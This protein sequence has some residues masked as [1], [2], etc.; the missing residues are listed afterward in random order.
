MAR[1]ANAEN[2]KRDVEGPDYKGAIDL[3]RGPI[4]TNQSDSSSLG[5]ENST[6]YKRIDKQMGVNRG[7]AK[8]FAAIDGMAPEKRDDHLRSLLGLLKHAGYGEFSDLVD[9]AQSVQPSKPNPDGDPDFDEVDGPP[10]DDS[11]LREAGGSEPAP[12]EA[13]GTAA[14][15]ATARAGKTKPLSGP[16]ALRKVRESTIGQAPPKLTVVKPAVPDATD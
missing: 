10:A 6:L 8:A 13:D 1:T 16:E 5:Q 14:V 15:K 3:I 4:R 2:V 7:A 9:R 12:G 11:D